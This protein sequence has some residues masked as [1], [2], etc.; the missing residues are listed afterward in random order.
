MQAGKNQPFWVRVKVPR[1][2]RAGVYQ[3]T[4]SLRAEGFKAAVPLKV[5]V[6]DFELPDRMTCTTAF[7]FSAG[8]VFRYQGITDPQQRREVLEK[9]WANYGAHHISP[10]DPAPLDRVAVTWPDIKP[11]KP[12]WQ[13][14]QPVTN[15][16]H[17]GDRSLLIFDDRKDANVEAVYEPLVPIPE[18]GLR[19]RF[20]YRTAIP[21][22]TFLVTL[23]HY[24]ASGKWISGGN[25]D[26]G[27]DGDGHWQ[28]FDRVL[29]KFP[30]GAKIVQLQLR[31]TTWTESGE[32]TG[33]AWFDDVSLTERRD[34]RGV[35]RRRRVRARRNC[36]QIEQEKLQVKLDFTAW[37]K[38]MERAI[39][40]Y[41]FNSFR[42]G[43]PGMGGGTFHSRQRA[44]AARLRRGHAVLQGDVRQL[45][46][47][48][49]GAPA[50]E[51][52]ARR[53]LRLLVRRARPEG[54]RRSSATASP[55]SR[56]RPRTSAAC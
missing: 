53:G 45:L 41:H 11:P 47:A 22:Q 20:W 19:L 44:G 18:G 6:Y 25:N 1:E 24:D 39:D 8:N 23:N 43:I 9:Y 33:L 31:A 34:R 36:P 2:A 10:Y 49:A 27:L 54:L 15:E 13:G 52:L 5:E 37:D 55:S 28:E 26:I 56:R 40:G 12:K 46:H 17:G 50:A 4:I 14:G 21:G 16:M 38:A 30:T 51:G 3:G 35:D 42:L 7:G 48:N 32:A 29:R